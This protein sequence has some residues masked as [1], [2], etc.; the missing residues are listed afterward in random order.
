MIANDR[1]LAVD[2]NASN[3]L[4]LEEILGESFALKCVTS[5]V[6]ALRVAPA[7]RPNVVLLD[8]MMPVLDGN[9]TC[10]QL[11]TQPE[12]CDTKILML[13]A[14]SDLADR[15]K[16]Y[17][18]GA[19]DYIAKPFDER[20]VGAKVRAWSDMVCRQQLDHVW[21]DVEKIREGVG[22]TL[23]SLIE[24]RDTETGDHLC[25]MRWYAQ[26]LAE[27]L[28]QAGPYSD[29]IDES[30]LRNLYCAAPLH[31]IGKIGISDAILLKP[32]RL[33]P[34]EFEEIK[35]HTLIGAD[36]LTRAA[37]TLP[38]ADYLEMAIRIARHHHE[39]FDGTGYPDGLAGES[40]P[41]AARIVAVADVFDALTSDRVY[42]K[43]ILPA[44]AAIEIERSAGSQFDPVVV[45][46]FLACFDLM[47]QAHE[48]FNDVN[49]LGIA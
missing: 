15:L 8:V 47:L 19:V 48:R 37:A 49:R 24:L 33:V 6:E 46:A 16:S 3:L 17:Q 42:H 27:Q 13:S 22:L 12:L 34:S 11:R 4:I 39:R 29:R 43:A 1:V 26:V 38:S 40:I 28:A 21:R 35:R 14:K 2:D 32:D 36:L 44:E 45:D 18:A 9:D 25:R 7:F 20:E 10:R 30:F 41:L 31:D 5:G 23:T